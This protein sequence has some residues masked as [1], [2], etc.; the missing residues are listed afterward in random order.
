[1]EVL[2]MGMKKVD[3]VF[4]FTACKGGKSR[5]RVRIL[6][7]E[8]LEGFDRLI[9]M[10]QLPSYMEP[11]MSVPNAAETIATAVAAHCGLDPART[12]WVEDYPESEGLAAGERYLIM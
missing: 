1:L 11:G 6:P 8:N 2:E 7:I 12:L 9:V 5:C 3:E 4:H 10:S